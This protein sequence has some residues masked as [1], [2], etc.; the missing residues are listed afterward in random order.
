MKLK[1]LIN[2]VNKQG[3]TI[4]EVAT[5][6][7]RSYRNVQ[8][9]LADGKLPYSEVKGNILIDELDIPTFIRLPKDIK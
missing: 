3:L 9:W 1:T 7:H 2:K 4:Q 6:Y 5:K 8:R